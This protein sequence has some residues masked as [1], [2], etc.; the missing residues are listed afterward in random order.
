MVPGNSTAGLVPRRSEAKTG[1]DLQTPVLTVALFTTDK[2]INKR[3]LNSM[4]LK[5]PGAVTVVYNST[6]LPG[7]KE[8]AH[9]THR[10]TMKTLG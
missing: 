10:H 5:G 6:V 3:M 7:K 1:I 8:A 9:A 2:R 4:P